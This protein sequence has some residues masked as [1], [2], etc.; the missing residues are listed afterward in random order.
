M[1]SSEAN[2]GNPFDEPE[3]EIVWKAWDEGILPH[4]CLLETTGGKVL[5]VVQKIFERVI[6]PYLH[7]G[8][9]RMV[10]CTGCESFVCLYE[11][12][13][14]D[15]SHPQD[16]LLRISDFV[17]LYH[18][19]SEKDVYH[20]ML[21]NLIHFNYSFYPPLQFIKRPGMNRFHYTYIDA[22]KM[23]DVAS[24]TDLDKVFLSF[25]LATKDTLI[26]KLLLDY[27]NSIEERTNLQAM[28]LSFNEAFANCGTDRQY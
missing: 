22:K 23:K 18:V 21:K 25:Q 1:K 28:L 16:Q 11:S 2:I 12:V 15:T 4:P 27:E 14:L 20:W 5:E 6:E 13:L 7:R 10:Y 8:E 26:E 24:K 17:K 19:Y 9:D 3:R